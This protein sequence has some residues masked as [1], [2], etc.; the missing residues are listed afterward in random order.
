MS[1]SIGVDVGGT[2]TDVVI[3]DH[4]RDQTTV[5]KVRSE[6]AEGNTV[7]QEIKDL[8]RKACFRRSWWSG[9]TR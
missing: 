7:S 4:I 6:A 5:A 1:L 3:F 2:F 9:P 8:R